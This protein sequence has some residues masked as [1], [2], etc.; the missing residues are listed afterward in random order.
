MLTDILDLTVNYWPYFLKGT[1]MTVVLSVSAVILGVMAG[2]IAALMRL[3][4]I[5]ALNYIATAYVDVFRGTP[6]IVQLWIF[7]LQLT[8]FMTF[9]KFSLWGVS[10]DEFIPCLAALAL[11]SGAYVSEIIRAGIQAVEKGQMEASRS[12]GMG[13]WMA[14]RLIIM[15][16]A[17]KNILPAIGNEFVS[18][19]KETAI[20]QYL[21]VADIMYCRN[22]VQMQ[23]YQPLPTY[24]IAAVIYFLLTFF[25]SKGVN[26]F[27]RRLKRSDRQAA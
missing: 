19:I 16:Q 5:K 13:H 8:Q 20:I 11:N 4:R 2:C 9:P 1:R 25:T 10:M 14:M 12:L 24:Y 22:A 17:I 27:E 23:T 26:L 21:G 18:M 6:L 7:Y 15:P 3:S